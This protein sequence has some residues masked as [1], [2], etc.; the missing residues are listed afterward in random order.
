MDMGEDR[1]TRCRIGGLAGAA[2]Q[3]KICDL[4]RRSS[5]IG[6]ALL[7][8]DHVVFINRQSDLELLVLRVGPA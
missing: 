5:A 3:C 6:K 8:G 7:R 4:H 2:K 1:A